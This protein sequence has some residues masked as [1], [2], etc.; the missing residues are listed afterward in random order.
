M[1]KSFYVFD[2]ACINLQYLLILTSYLYYLS[3]ESL[4]HIHYRKF[5]EAR[6]IILLFTKTQG[7]PINH[8]KFCRYRLNTFD[9]FPVAG[10]FVTF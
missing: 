6:N 1:N 7:N 4:V 2:N 3:V 10:Y 9:T 8:K 5:M